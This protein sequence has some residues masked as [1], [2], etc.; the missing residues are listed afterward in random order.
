MTV[1]PN[2]AI[3]DLFG[4]VEP[5]VSQKCPRCKSSRIRRGYRPTPIWLK[6]VFIYNL[7]CDHCNWEFR[8]IA[9]PGT[10]GKKK[11]N[12]RPKKRREK[13]PAER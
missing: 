2:P 6:V 12:Q 10:V 4:V 5:M 1:L 13:E 8:G 3:A 11:A 7:L 9:V